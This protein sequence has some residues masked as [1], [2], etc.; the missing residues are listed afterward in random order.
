M[1]EGEEKEKGKF[2]LQGF[3]CYT[4]FFEKKKKVHEPLVLLIKVQK[5]PIY[6]S[7]KVQKIKK[8]MH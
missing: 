4:T 3:G 1:R 6:L 5:P 7:W 8:V 2:H